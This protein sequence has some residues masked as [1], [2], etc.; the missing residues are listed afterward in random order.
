MKQAVEIVAGSSSRLV[1]LE[2]C[3]RK[4]HTHLRRGLDATVGLGQELAK[5]KKL[6]L[7]LERCGDFHKYCAEYHGW[8]PRTVGRFIAVADSVKLLR[9]QGLELPGNETQVSELARLEPEHQAEVWKLVRDIAEKHECAITADLVH[10]VVED[11]EAKIIRPKAA[12]VAKQSPSRALD[13]SD[14]Q[15]GP[16]LSGDAHDASAGPLEPPARI[17]LSEQ[18]ERDLV[19]IRRLCGDVVADAIEYLRL[20]MSERELRQWAAQ[21]DPEVLTHYILDLRWSLAKALGFV[22][23]TITDRTPVGR[24]ITMAM[25]NNGHFEVEMQEVKITVNR[26]I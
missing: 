15:V 20:E 1:L 6:E 9:D 8:D 19:R 17:Q 16:D 3:E 7:F 23:Q 21:E 5:I 11:Y 26:L 4:I 2:E 22:N 14:L 10:D 12:T 25:A 13:G 18:G 24:L